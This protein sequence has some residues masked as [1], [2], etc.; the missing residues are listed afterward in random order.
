MIPYKLN[1]DYPACDL[2]GRQEHEQDPYTGEFLNEVLVLGKILANLL[3]S[4][5]DIKLE[6]VFK[7]WDWAKALYAQCSGSPGNFLELDKG[8]FTYLKKFVE[9]HKAMNVVAKAQFL[10]IFADA[11]KEY[12]K[13]TAKD[14]TQKAETA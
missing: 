7:H 14:P 8:D 12:E 2:A 9:E 6:L 11:E 5:K 10:K 4:S 3:G 1:F 13:A